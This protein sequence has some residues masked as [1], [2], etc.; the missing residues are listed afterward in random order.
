MFSSR[1]L[2]HAYLT[3]ELFCR[4]GIMDSTGVLE[5]ITEKNVETPV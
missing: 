3:A 1:L 4:K 5:L 2:T